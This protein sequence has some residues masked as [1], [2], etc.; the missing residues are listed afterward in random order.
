M[1]YDVHQLL[2]HGVITSISLH[3]FLLTHFNVASV[4]FNFLARP[5]Y[6]CFKSGAFSHW[7]RAVDGCLKSGV[8]SH[9]SRVVDGCQDLLLLA[10]TQ[11][12]DD[13]DV[14]P[15]IVSLWSTSSRHHILSHVILLV[16]NSSHVYHY[17]ARTFFVREFPFI[18]PLMNSAAAALS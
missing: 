2:L 16:L 1:N 11:A 9:W 13:H 6:H 7:S 17:L 18:L 8:F 3:P 15:R 14:L 12:D 4:P 5:S 10:D